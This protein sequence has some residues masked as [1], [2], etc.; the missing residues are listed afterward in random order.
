MPRPLRQ[1]PFGELNGSQSNDAPSN[2][3]L[4]NGSLSNSSLSN[5]AE[6]QPATECFESA[7]HMRAYE[8]TI[9]GWLLRFGL[10][11]LAGTFAWLVLD[12]SGTVHS[13]TSASGLA[14]SGLQVISTMLPTGTQQLVVVDAQ[15]R[16][17]AVYQIEPGQGKIQLKS[18][19][20][21]T[22]DLKMEQ[23]NAQSPL[24][25]ELKQVQPN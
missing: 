2:K 25:S 24:P 21:L 8:R 10:V 19:R 15:A 12:S 1:N 20:A 23:F 11:T 7:R 4:S 22:W 6:S 3:S 5:E 14:D 18:V 13:Q 9:R 16:T 17:L